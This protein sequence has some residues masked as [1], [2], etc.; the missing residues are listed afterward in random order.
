MTRNEIKKLPIYS[1]NKCATILAPIKM[2]LS[3]TFTLVLV[4]FPLLGKVSKYFLYKVHIIVLIYFNND[5]NN[6]KCKPIKSR[7]ALLV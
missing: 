4:E 5:N 7:Q 3:Q 2:H 1:I 6:Y